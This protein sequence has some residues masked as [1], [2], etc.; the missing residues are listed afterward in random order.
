MKPI[1]KRHRMNIHVFGGG[2][3]ISRIPHGREEPAHV[4]VFGPDLEEGLQKATEMTS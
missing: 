2:D 3:F 1:T 4:N